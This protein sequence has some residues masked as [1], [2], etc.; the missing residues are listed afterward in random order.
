LMVKLEAMMVPE[1]LCDFALCQFS[2][3][4]TYSRLSF[5][6]GGCWCPC[7][8]RW[9]T[10]WEI[11]RTEIHRSTHTFAMLRYDIII[12]FCGSDG[13]SS[14]QTRSSITPSSPPLQLCLVIVFHCVFCPVG[15]DCK[16]RK[17]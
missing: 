4:W 1:C 12:I 13:L 9:V 8:G 6:P 17:L 3:P 2:I 15:I 7:G 11:L 16:C 5:S 14:V 10:R